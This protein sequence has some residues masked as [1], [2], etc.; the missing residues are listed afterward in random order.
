MVLD[1]IKEHEKAIRELENRLYTE[2]DTYLLRSIK[3]RLREKRRD[4]NKL[5]GLENARKQDK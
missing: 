4:L 1:P 5:K 3:R 2:K